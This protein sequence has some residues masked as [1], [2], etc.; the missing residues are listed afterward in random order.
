MNEENQLNTNY[1][2]ID[3]EN[4]RDYGSCS[5]NDETN[6]ELKSADDKDNSYW[7]I[8]FILLGSFLF[9]AMF[10]LVHF[11]PQ[12]NTFTLVA[13][14]SVVQI[15]LSVSCLFYQGKNP[16]GQPGTRVWLLV[17]GLFG[18][19]GVTA[20]FFGLQKL[21]LSD[22]V[23]LQ[24]TT[25]VFAAAFAVGLLGEPW[26]RFDIIGAVVCFSGVALITHPTW[27]LGP[28]SAADMDDASTPI[29]AAM[30]AVAVLVTEIGA[31]CAGIAYVA[32][33]KVND[34]SDA[35]AI[36][37]VLYYAVISIPLC[38][39]GSGLLLGE[40]NIFGS[41]EELSPYDYFLLV[42]MGLAGYGGQW[43]YNLGL[44]RIAVARVS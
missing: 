44:Q 21:P 20:V 33:R 26:T 41:T 4:Q 23:T 31:A 39:L 25:P 2:T 30:K 16:L 10:L 1:Q 38:I 29:S 40:W 28:P 34:T 32:V 14:R 22:A 17:R 24:F 27:L 6:K 12:T 43:F 8:C 15:L 35:A 36:V 13:Y 3:E 19:L 37:M 9:S 18:S 7:G 42:V 11:F 5:Q